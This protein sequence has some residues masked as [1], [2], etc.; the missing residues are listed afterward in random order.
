ML[1]VLLFVCILIVNQPA[2][3]ESISTIGITD[4]T[5][6]TS[7]MASTER[8]PM[9]TESLDGT[10]MST[11]GTK[12]TTETTDGSATE[13]RLTTEMT[14][15]SATEAS[16]MTSV[17]PSETLVTSYTDILTDFTHVSSNATYYCVFTRKEHR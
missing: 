11:D 7:E 13:A 2:E 16:L 4:T 14:D 9:T 5:V 8:T 3:S 15:G 17:D 1:R 10:P 6:V 12:L